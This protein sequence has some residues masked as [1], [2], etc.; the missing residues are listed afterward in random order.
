MPK[1]M[2]LSFLVIFLLLH[3]SHAKCRPRQLPNPADKHIFILAGQSNMSGRGGV[4]NGTWNGYIP[5]ASH[6]SPAILRLSAALQWEEAREPL[7]ADIDINKT[8]GVGPGMAFAGGISDNIGLVPCAIG[9]TKIMQW[10]RGGPLYS[11]MV[12]RARE[13]LKEGGAITAL[14]WYQGESDTITAEEADAYKANMEK[15]IKDVRLDLGMPLLPVIQVALASGEGPYIET[16]REAQMSIALPNV[17]WVDAKGL[18]LNEDNL[19][20]TTGAQAQLGRMLARAF[21]THFPIPRF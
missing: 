16:V 14:L 8:C 7:H 20:L 9:G 18:P 10:Q 13:G 21:L 19:H 2:L 12:G 11:N 15:F 3:S 6:P 4:R 17:V 1:R 5:L